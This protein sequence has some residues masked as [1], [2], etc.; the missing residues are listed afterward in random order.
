MSEKWKNWIQS[1][2]INYINVVIA[3]YLICRVALF[4]YFPMSWYLRCFAVLFFMAEA[5][6]LLHAVG[7]FRY[8]KTVMRANK[9]KSQREPP[10]PKL[11]SYPPVAIVVASY[12]EPLAVLEDTLVCFHNLTY[13]NKH[14]YF[15]D[16]TR[17]DKPWDTPQKVEEY[18]LAVE[19]LCRFVGINLFRRKW[20]HAKA[21]MINDF[22]EFLGGSKNEDFVLIEGGDT[23]KEEQKYIIIFDADMN[24]LPNFVEPLMAIMESQPDVAFVQTPQYYTNFKD[25]R[26]A[27]AASLM[28]VV[29]Y[30]WICE[31]KGIQ[32]LMIFCGTNVILRIEALN[33]VGGIDLTS[34]TEDF[35]TAFKLHRRKWRSVYVNKVCAFGM[36]PEDLGALFKQQHRWALGTVGMLP[37]LLGSLL[38]NPFK[39]SF[40]FW[41]EYFLSSSYYLVGWMYFILMLAP[42]LYI[43]FDVRTYMFPTT[44]YAALMV[45]Y[46]LL[47]NVLFYWSLCQRGYA[48]K[49]LLTGMVL[50]MVAIPVFMSASAMALLGMRGQFV[51][52]PKGESTSLPLRDLWPQIAMGMAFFAALCWGALRLIFEGDHAFAVTVNMIWLS[53]YF[54]IMSTVFYFN[55]PQEEQ[56]TSQAKLAEAS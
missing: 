53:F 10:V 29:F 4:F 1:W 26:V 16:D 54:V 42:L 20:H 40:S 47:A 51:V 49:D 11:T 44:I 34:V 56:Q 13:P 48:F 5:F 38:R 33:Q 35:A 30:E 9:D 50:G 31:A 52:T 14:L 39:H 15:L 43:F 41:W 18:K 28:Q 55:Q 19:S 2:L 25:N 23:P 36:G 8:V 3:A 24:P 22:L 17:Y 45:P 12:K 37:K 7:Y 6:F 32:N 27:R 21:G 46:I